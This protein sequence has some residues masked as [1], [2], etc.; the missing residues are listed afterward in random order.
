M[1]KQFLV[2]FPEVGFLAC[3]AFLSWQTLWCLT[4][5][6]KLFF[7][8]SAHSLPMSSEGAW[9]TVKGMS[10]SGRNEYIMKIPSKIWNDLNSFSL[11]RGSVH[12]LVWREKE[13]KISL[14]NAQSFSMSLLSQQGKWKVRA[15]YGIRESS[16]WVLEAL[17][18]SASSKYSS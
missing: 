2:G 7:F 3:Q 13:P 17:R 10:Q 14:T 9:I 11:N 12:W 18:L 16:W 1:G 5:E 15:F 4:M 8:L 6:S